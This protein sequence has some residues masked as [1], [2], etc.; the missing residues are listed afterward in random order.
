MLFQIFDFEKKSNKEQLHILN[1]EF[2]IMKNW[3]RQVQLDTNKQA[4]A[5]LNGIH[6]KLVYIIAT[7]KEML[8]TLLV[9]MHGFQIF[10]C[11]RGL[12]KNLNLN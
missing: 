4:L 11:I 8:S 2:Y 5:H 12:D 3:I 1:N 7:E 6:L 10:K 9:Y